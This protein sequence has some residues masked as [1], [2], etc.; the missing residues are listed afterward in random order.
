MSK[1]TGIFE[2]LAE[3]DYIPTEELNQRLTNK[4]APTTLLNFLGNRALYPESIPLTKEDAE[5]DLALL[6]ELIIK[7]PQLIYNQESKKITLDQGLVNRFPPLNKLIISL[8]EALNLSGITQV[9]IKNDSNVSLIGSIIAVAAS[10][11]SIPLT[12]NNINHDLTIDTI[13]MI[14]ILDQHVT[15]KIG[16]GQEVVVAGGELGVVFDTRHK[17]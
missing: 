8:V 17:I 9:F 4:Q 7:E 1:L 6:R 12:L 14:P 10:T 13:S 11:E 5:V 15:L 16:S 3:L 2:K